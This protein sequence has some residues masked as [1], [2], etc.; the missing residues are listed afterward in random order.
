MVFYCTWIQLQALGHRMQTWPT[1][2]LIEYKCKWLKLCQRTVWFSHY[3][4]KAK[5]LGFSSSC[6]KMIHP[7]IKTLTVPPLMLQRIQ[8]LIKVLVE[9]Q[10]THQEDIRL[11]IHLSGQNIVA[12]NQELWILNQNHFQTS[13]MKFGFNQ[14]PNL[15]ST[16]SMQQLS[17]IIS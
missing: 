12:K 6:T 2:A 10:Y 16:S 1:S 9:Q 17:K 7:R 5:R 13:S 14:D 15:K 3:L 4:P 11:M 8:H